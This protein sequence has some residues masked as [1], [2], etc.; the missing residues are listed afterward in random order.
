MGQSGMNTILEGELEKLRP[1][2]MHSGILEAE[3]K[4][5]LK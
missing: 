1:F 5:C 2:W 4:M 3:I